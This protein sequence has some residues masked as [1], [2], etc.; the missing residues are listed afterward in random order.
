MKYNSR[1]T[2][3]SSPTTKNYSCARIFATSGFM[4][5][6]DGYTNSENYTA[7]LKDSFYLN[8]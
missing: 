4:K 3:V 6:H 1:C 5:R 2:A 8:P 7:T